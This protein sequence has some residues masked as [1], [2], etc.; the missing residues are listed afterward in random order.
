M[1]GLELGVLLLLCGCSTPDETSYAST[2]CRKGF[3]KELDVIG[4]GLSVSLYCCRG[5][6]VAALNSAFSRALDSDVGDLLTLAETARGMA[7]TPQTLELR[8]LLNVQLSKE[9]LWK[10]ALRHEN[11]II[12]E[13]TARIQAQDF[14]R[15]DLDVLVQTLRH[16]YC[17]TGSSQ[18]TREFH[19][20]REL[21]AS[22][23]DTCNW[24]Q[25]AHRGKGKSKTLVSAGDGTWAVTDEK[26]GRE[27]SSAL[28]GLSMRLN[29]TRR[30]EA[31]RAQEF[32]VETLR[33]GRSVLVKI[34]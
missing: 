31:A 14:N 9:D 15:D 21:S 20:S 27:L 22:L 12:D 18:G 32:V 25:A 2:A 10:D 6:A 16:R 34:E 26:G 17:I 5:D 3:D 19:L 33:S 13:L 28:E 24:M 8:R 1:K 23:A 30:V 29:K 11:T 7:P 4:F